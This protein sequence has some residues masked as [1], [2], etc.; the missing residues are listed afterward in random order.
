M[1]Q[2]NSSSK[3]KSVNRKIYPISAEATDRLESVGKERG[4]TRSE[5]LRRLEPVDPTFSLTQFWRIV[6]GGSAWTLD[7]FVYVAAALGLDP[8]MLLD[9]ILRGHDIMAQ[10]HAR[11]GPDGVDDGSQDDS[12]GG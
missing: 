3:R 2:D 9:R 10:L 11:A 8:P 7:R 4:L 6:S 12:G 5:I 1:G